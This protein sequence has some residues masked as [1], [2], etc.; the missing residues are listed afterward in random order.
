MDL[1]SR[2]YDDTTPQSVLS[3]VA[4]GLRSTYHSA[5]KGSPVQVVFGRD[6][7][8]NSTYL[9]NWKFI[10][11]RK[12]HGILYNNARKNKNNVQFD[13]QPGQSVYVVNTDIKRKLN[14]DKEGPFEIISAHTN[15][16]L[17]IRSSPTV[18]E[19]INIRRVHPVW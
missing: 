6:M 9:A 19:K 14:P 18:T 8:V 16:T 7:I 1:P 3:A 11:Q 10:K 2:P 4:W 5:L 13:Y 12:E 17:T 15:G